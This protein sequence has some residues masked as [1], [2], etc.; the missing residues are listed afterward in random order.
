MLLYFCSPFI[1]I[2]Y[3][4]ALGDRGHYLNNRVFLLRNYRLIFAGGNLMFLKQIIAREA[5][6]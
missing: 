3:S 6:L 4:E 1:D 2:R 5:N